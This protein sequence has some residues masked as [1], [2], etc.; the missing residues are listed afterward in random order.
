MAT[1]EDYCGIWTFKGSAGPSADKAYP[2]DG[3]V[4]IESLA[5]GG[6]ELRVV[7][8]DSDQVD[9]TL[10]GLTLNELGH[11]TATNVRDLATDLCWSITIQPSSTWKNRRIQATVKAAGGVDVGEGD[12]SGTWG[13]EAHTSPPPVPPATFA[14]P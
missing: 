8:T 3:Q 4:K 12:L 6:E 9:H 2:F 13:A 14:A 5:G 11:L 1:P 10:T 7:W